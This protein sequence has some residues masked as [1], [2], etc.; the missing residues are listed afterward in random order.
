MPIVSAAVQNFD[1]GAGAELKRIVQ[2]F[3]SIGIFQPLHVGLLLERDF[4]PKK[5]AGSLLLK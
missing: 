3:Y 2:I 5:E 1:N 4:R